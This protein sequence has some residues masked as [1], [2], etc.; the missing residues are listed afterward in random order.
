MVILVRQYYPGNP[1]SRLLYHS[2]LG[3]PLAISNV[4]PYV[5]NNPINWVDPK[6]T[7]GVLPAIGIIAGAWVIGGWIGVVIDWWPLYSDL[8]KEIDRT[9]KEIAERTTFH[10]Q[11]IGSITEEELDALD[12]LYK[13]L[14][15][16]SV[17]RAEVAKIILVE[18]WKMYLNLIIPSARAEDHLQK[19]CVNNK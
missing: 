16:L 13:R 10:L 3:N 17:T 9:R 5:G 6:G 8:S 2:S 14:D 1:I 4:Y 7:I 11:G 15:W 12:M 19:G 18:Y